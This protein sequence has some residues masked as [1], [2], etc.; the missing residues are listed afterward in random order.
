M[1][2]QSMGDFIHIGFR[3][4]IFGLQC[5]NFV[6]GALK[7]AKNPFSFS[8]TSKLLSSVTT[9][10]IM[11]PL[12]RS[13]VRTLDRAVSEKSAIFLSTSAVLDHHVGIA[14]LNFLRKLRYHLPLFFGQVA[15]IQ[16]RFLRRL[17]R[18]C[19]VAAGATGA[20]SA[21]G[22]RVKLGTSLISSLMPRFLLWNFKLR[23]GLYRQTSIF[24]QSRTFLC[25]ALLSQ[26][27]FLE[28]KYRWKYP[29]PHLQ[30]GHPADFQ[31]PD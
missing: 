28:R 21:K 15:L 7:E 8:S 20:S 19:T 29:W 11:S 2:F 4:V 5:G 1:S 18:R 6:G 9:P 3:F 12:P 31:R 14:Q 25:Q 16:N 26:H 10:E 30:T 17:G 13:L 27:G 24:L 23:N 22:S